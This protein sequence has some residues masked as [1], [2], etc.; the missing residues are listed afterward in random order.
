MTA[1]DFLLGGAVQ[2]RQSDLAFRAAVD[3]PLLAAFAPAKA[4]DVVL[5]IGC[6]AGAAMLCAA[7]R[8][9]DAR[10]VGLD[11]Q[12]DLCDRAKENA[13]LNGW[14]DRVSALCGDVADPNLKMDMVDVVI[15]NPPFLSAHAADP[16]QDPARRL[17]M[18]ESTADWPLWADFGLGR[19]KPGG[20]FV[21]VQR[22]D[23]TPELLAA[24]TPALGDVTIVPIRAR[25]GDDA[26]RVLI[27]GRKGAR[28]PA[29]LT[30]GLTLHGDGG[31]YSYQANRILCAPV[32]FEAAGLQG[33]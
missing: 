22:A 6:G 21:L 30:A 24:L 29:R 26:S 2:L 14:G 28:G 5:D 16:P 20:W 32:A 12:R 11:V 1:P 17:A 31:D 13:A 9:G 23:R 7:A 25:A 33:S 19:L 4:R 27:R 18:V 8:V 10:F 3:A 15:T